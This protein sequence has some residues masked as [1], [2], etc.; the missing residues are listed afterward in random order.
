MR[1]LLI[2][3][4]RA[5]QRRLL[6]RDA[7]RVLT[8]DGRRRFRRAA[9]GLRTEMPEI[10]HIATSPLVRARET[11]TLLASVYKHKNVIRQ[12]LLAPGKPASKLAAWLAAQSAKSCIA[13]VGHEPDL[14]RCAGLLLTGQPRS[15]LHFKKGAAA[16]IEFPNAAR[17]GGGRLCWL[18]SA[19]QLAALA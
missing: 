2:R 14:G 15:C 9:R 12:P 13:L 19:R 10:T 17:A 16:L 1:I 4:A 11:A 7:S 18:L 5:E 3:H 8:D 6:Q